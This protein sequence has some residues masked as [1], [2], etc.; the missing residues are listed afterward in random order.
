MVKE[1]FLALHACFLGDIAGIEQ[2]RKFREIVNIKFYFVINDFLSEFLFADIVLIKAHSRV[3]GFFT[4]SPDKYLVPVFVQQQ[5]YVCVFESNFTAFWLFH[6]CS[7][8]YYYRELYK[9]KK[10]MSIEFGKNMLVL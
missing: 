10:M 7:S 6:Y 3:S 2:I 5:V 1:F 4:N 8:S 9:K